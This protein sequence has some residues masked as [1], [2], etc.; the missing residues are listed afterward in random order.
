MSMM[1]NATQSGVQRGSAGSAECCDTTA[2]ECG[3]TGR[4]G[5][6][7]FRPSVD[8]IETDAAYSVQ[9]DMPGCDPSAIDVNVTGNELTISGR[10]RERRLVGDA[11]LREYAVDDF[12]RS[13]RLGQGIDTGHV[14]ADYTNG[15]LT[16]TLPKVESVRVRKVDVR[17][18]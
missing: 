14:R 9:L 13:F 4:S 10:V 3:T 17:T 18:N 7:V 5:A 8:I 1:Q 6:V 15:V 2:C 11:L 12:A 16:V